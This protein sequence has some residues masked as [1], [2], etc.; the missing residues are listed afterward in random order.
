MRWSTSAL[1]HSRPPLSPQRPASGQ[2]FALSCD[3]YP[4]KST[5]QSPD[6]SHTTSWATEIDMGFP[7]VFGMNCADK[8][9]WVGRTPK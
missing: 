9:L 6:D 4:R 7:S 2:S 1:L 3:D 5:R 8:P